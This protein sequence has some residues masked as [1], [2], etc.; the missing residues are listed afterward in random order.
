VAEA[1]SAAFARGMRDEQ[2]CTYD[3]LEVP[4]SPTPV[5]V[6]FTSQKPF[7]ANFRTADH[8][9]KWILGSAPG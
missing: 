6:R 2:I 5:V 1:N 9:D 4:K 7:M 3:L 8:T